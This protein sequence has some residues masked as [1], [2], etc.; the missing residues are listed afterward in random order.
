[1]IN[2]PVQYTSDRPVA[3]VNIVTVQFGILVASTNDNL[4]KSAALAFSELVRLRSNSSLFTLDALLT[5]RIHISR[6]PGQKQLAKV[7]EVHIGD[8]WDEKEISLWGLWCA[9][10]VSVDGNLN[11]SDTSRS[12]RT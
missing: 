4:E 8:F 9:R 11:V 7:Q 5:V 10:N 1:M 3:T 12:T 2:V 6:P